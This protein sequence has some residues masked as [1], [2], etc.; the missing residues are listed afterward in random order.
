MVETNVKRRAVIDLGT[1]TFNLLIAEVGPKG[2][3]IIYH[4]KKPVLL[5]M[6][7]INEGQIANDAL[8]RARETLILFQENALNCAR[9]NWWPLVPLRC[10]EQVIDTPCWISLSINWGCIF[11]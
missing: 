6:G 1:N 11:E 7:G 3:K 4:D 8:K 2:L 10:E 5:G 9:L